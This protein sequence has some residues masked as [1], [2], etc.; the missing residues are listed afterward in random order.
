MWRIPFLLDAFTYTGVYKGYLSAAAHPQL[1]EEPYCPHCPH[2]LMGPCVIEMP[3]DF[4]VGNADADPQLEEAVCT[5]QK[6][7]VAAPDLGVVGV[8]FK[9]SVYFIE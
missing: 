8:E 3:P 9:G 2:C 7:L 4:L 5:L 1:R 6:V